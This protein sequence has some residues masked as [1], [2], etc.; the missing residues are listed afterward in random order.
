MLN[1]ASADDL[2]DLVRPD[3]ATAAWQDTDDQPPEAAWHA[4]TTR[5][6]PAGDVLLVAMAEDTRHHACVLFPA[7]ADGGEAAIAF[8]RAGLHLGENPFLGRWRWRKRWRTCADL[9][10]LAVAFLAEPWARAIRYERGGREIMAPVEPADAGR[11]VIVDWDDPAPVDRFLAVDFADRVVPC[12]VPFLPYT[13]PFLAVCWQIY[14]E[15]FGAPEPEASLHDWIGGIFYELDG[16][17]FED[18]TFALLKHLD[19]RTQGKGLAH[20]GAGPI[21]GNGHWFY[22]RLERETDIPPQNV[23]SALLLERPEFL[24]DDVA[25]RYHRLMRGLARRLGEEWTG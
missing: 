5:R 19:A 22:D 23:F 16:D 24:P 10:V 11:C 6:S 25:A 12:A 9:G 15:S 17:P 20:L 21:Y 8:H 3:V 13:G 18:M 2:L 7:E 4:V 14:W 1:G